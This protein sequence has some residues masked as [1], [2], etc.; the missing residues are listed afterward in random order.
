MEHRKVHRARTFFK[1]QIVLNNR[2]AT[3]DC[4]VRNLSDAEA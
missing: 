1:G 3:L 4:L 2:N